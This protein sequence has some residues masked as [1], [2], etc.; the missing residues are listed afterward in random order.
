MPIWQF[1]KNAKKKILNYK[2]KLTLNMLNVE[3]NTDIFS[4][5]KLKTKQLK[6][7]ILLKTVN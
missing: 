7:T 5:L 4:F 2:I 1:G 3:E 6:L